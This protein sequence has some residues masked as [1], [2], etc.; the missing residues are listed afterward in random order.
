MTP[1]PRVT[2]PDQVDDPLTFAAY[3]Q[4]VIGTPWPTIKDQMILRRRIKQ[5]F[6]QFPQAD[7]RTLVSVVHYCRARKRRPMHAWTVIDRFRDA[8]AA[9]WVPEL[10]RLPEDLEVDREVERALEIETDPEWRRR[11]IGARGQGREEV[12]Q[13]WKKARVNA[14]S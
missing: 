12:L 4:R 8:W 10:D 5:F 7:Y 9:G 14:S 13:Q 11:L 3:A 2:R 6:T 1:P